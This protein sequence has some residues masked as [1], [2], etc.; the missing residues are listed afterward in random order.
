LKLELV[1][2][3]CQILPTFCLVV[4]AV[5]PGMT[6]GHPGP[7]SPHEGDGRNVRCRWKRHEAEHSPFPDSRYEN[8]NS[9][10]GLQFNVIS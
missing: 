9:R 1:F 7:R 2:G 5:S 3:T 4:F 6:F 8:D 10:R